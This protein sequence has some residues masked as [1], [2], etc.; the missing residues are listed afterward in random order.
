MTSVPDDIPLPPNAHLWVVD[1]ITE[2]TASIEV[3]GATAITV[4]VW[5][6]PRDVG[7]G[8]VLR[9]KHDRRGDRSIFMIVTDDDERRRRVGRSAKLMS[10][11]SKNDT[12]GDVTL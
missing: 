1:Q 8:D 2:Q 6:L 12:P 4:P 9:V 10:R 7:E 11:P 3:D 5:M